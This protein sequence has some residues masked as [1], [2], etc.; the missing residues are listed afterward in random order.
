MRIITLLLS[1][2]IISTL[3]G[4]NSP[5][6]YKTEAQ[7]QEICQSQKRMNAET[8]EQLRKYDVTEDKK[9]KLEYFFYTN[10]KE[11]A[12]AL[13][14][15]LQKLGYVG[16][17]D[18]SASDKMEFVITGWTTPIRMDLDSVTSWTES[19]CTTGMKHDCEFDGWGTNPT[20]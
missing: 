20:Q 4:A 14:A 18:T 2:G 9:L 16:S 13:A 17:Y 19:M 8:I 3:F 5:K 15:D 1:M 11:K 10:A 12:E 6:P 7:Y